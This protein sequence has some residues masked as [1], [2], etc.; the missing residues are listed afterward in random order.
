[1]RRLVLFI[2]GSAVVWIACANENG[3]WSWDDSTPRSHANAPAKQPSPNPSKPAT[4]AAAAPTREAGVNQRAQE[5]VAGFEADDFQSKIERQS[6]PS[7]AKPSRTVRFDWPPPEEEPDQAANETGSSDR[8]ARPTETG[9]T[10]A[11]VASAHGTP[12]SKAAM[13]PAGPKSAPPAAG[14]PIPPDAASEQSAMKSPELPRDAIQ[15]DDRTHDA[16]TR[17]PMSP[18]PERADSSSSGGDGD[19]RA[20]AEPAKSMRAERVAEPNER[21]HEE[22][23]KPAN[24]AGTPVKSSPSPAHAEVTE[25]SGHSA[26]GSPVLESVTVERSS[27]HASPTRTSSDQ[28]AEHEAAKPPAAG[29]NFATLASQPAATTEL[30]LADTIREVEAAVARNPDDLEQQ[31][32]LR[33]L[34]LADGQNEKALADTPGM[35]VEAQRVLR[36]LVHSLV[37]A[38]SEVGR[39]P[40]TWAT[41]QLE[42]VE[43]MRGLLRAKADLRIPVI[44]LCTRVE[45]FGVYEPID[46]P[47]FPANTQ[48]Q[49]ILYVEVDNFQVD[50]TPRGQ[51]RTLMAMRTTLIAQDGSEVWSS[52]DDNIEDLVRRPR[53]DF[54]LVK[55]LAIPPVL[56]AGSYTLK[57]EIEDKLA[58]KTNSGSVGVKLAARSE[59]QP[60]R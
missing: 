1:M 3:P 59:S 40:A 41:R 12:A 30:S 47:E 56:P 53:K 21:S 8:P 9:R 29:E 32:R 11:K 34:Y 14:S 20:R 33:M 6:A 39:D 27:S 4:P 54:Y 48:N 25:T 16:S 58:G 22:I 45:G 37:E 50:H 43:E 55:D 60:G 44:S 18:N 46:P 36:S 28:P 13:S 57:V 51:Y 7:R 2:I 17:K 24:E 23:G 19:R 10:E 38:R 49:A 35:N 31:V 42:A 26:P 15:R 5:Y 52:Y